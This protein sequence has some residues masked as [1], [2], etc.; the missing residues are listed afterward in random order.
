M[1]MGRIGQ[2]LMCRTQGPKVQCLILHPA[3][4]FVSPS[5]DQLLAKVCAL[6]SGELLSKPA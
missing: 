5:A 2:L 4:Y 6:G 1:G 3:T